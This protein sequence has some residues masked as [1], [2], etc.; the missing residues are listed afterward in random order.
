MKKIILCIVLCFEMGF[1]FQKMLGINAYSLLSEKRWE[2]DS[3]MLGDYEI[4][5]PN[6][7]ENAFLSFKENSVFGIAGCNNYFATF[8]ILGNG[9][10]IQVQ[11]GGLTRKMC[12]STFESE[13]EAI[14]TKNFVGNFIV[15]GDDESITLVKENFQIRLIPSLFFEP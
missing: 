3:M 2:I 9:K 8:R 15:Q 4:I 5:I 11:P 6:E 10:M 1:S 14:F 13:I 7:V 12:S